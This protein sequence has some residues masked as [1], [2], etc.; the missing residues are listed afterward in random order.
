MLLG[1]GFFFAYRPVPA[2]ACEPGGAC[3]IPASRRNPRI[4]LWSVAILA[5]GLMTYPYWGAAAVHL[6]RTA[7]VRNSADRNT[8]PAALGGS[9]VVTLDISG[10]TCSACAGEIEA[11]LDQVPGVASADVNFEQSRATVRVATLAPS[12]QALV[13]AVEAAGYHA[14]PAGQTSAKPEGDR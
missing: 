7:S 9:E 10:M 6:A 1:A 11:K 12:M 13:S 14:T 8:Q 4:V 2:A 5:V 3:S